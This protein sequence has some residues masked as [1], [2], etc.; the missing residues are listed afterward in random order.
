MTL[1]ALRRAVALVFA[2]LLC[3]V[4]YWLLRV[5]GPL[6]MEQRG[7]WGHAC[8][9]PIMAALGIKCGVVGKAPAGGLV[10]SNHLSHLD[11]LIYGNA[12]PC[13]FVSKAEVAGW[14]F[15]G[16][17]SRTGGT[18]YLDR[19]SRA[20]AQQV[21]AKME[22]RLT[23]P[24]AVV[25]F[26]EGTSTDGSKV[27]RFHSRL[28]EPAI[29]SGA[30]VTAASVRYI[31]SDGTPERE[32]CWFGDEP[33]MPHLWKTLGTA[34]FSAEVTFGEPRVYTDRRTA[35]AQTQEEIEAMRAGGV[36]TVQ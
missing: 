5:R 30:P 6:T 31:L 33:F 14:P 18:I 20:S 36:L 25:L 15:F 1:R 12:L 28:F 16:W 35:A 3:V 10:V 21:A 24:L 23:G 7:Q 27:L 34:G 22:E 9:K 26:P 2:L 11:I 4:R 17:M 29:A 13:F 32:L 8:G 19:G